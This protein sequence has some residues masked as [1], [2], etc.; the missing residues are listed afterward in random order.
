M[1]GDDLESQL[2]SQLTELRTQLAEVGA[3]HAADPSCDELREQ[4]LAA[5]Q[6]AIADLEPALLEVA[7]DRLL[8]SCDSASLQGAGCQASGIEEAAPG[9][10]ERAAAHLL[11]SAQ[12]WGQAGGGARLQASPREQEDERNA[13]GDDREEEEAEEEE[14]EEE[15]VNGS[16]E[17]VSAEGEEEGEEEEA[18]LQHSGLGAPLDV[19]AHARLAVEAGVHQGTLHYAAWE[20]HSRGIASKLLA[21]M[22][23]VKG[24]GLGSRGTGRVEPLQVLL[25]A[26][27]QGLGRGLQGQQGQ[28]EAAG[29]KAAASS[30]APA[31]AARP[32][33][34][35]RLMDQHGRVDKCQQAVAHF[36]A[37]LQ[38]N[39]DNPS[40]AAQVSKRLREAQ[41]SLAGAEAEAS[42]MSRALRDAGSGS[43]MKRAD[44][45]QRRVPV[46][47]APAEARLDAAGKPLISPGGRVEPAAGSNLLQAARTTFGDVFTLNLVGQRM[48][49]WFDPALIHTFFSAPDCLITFRP[50]VEQ[51]TQRVFGLPSKE[52]FPRHSQLLTDLRE[53]LPQTA[54]TG[55]L[56]VELYGAVRRLVF[57]ASVEVLF[58]APFMD[59]LWGRGPGRG[60]A[61]TPRPSGSAGGGG[62]GSSSRGEGGGRRV[63]PLPLEKARA[64][65][66]SGGAG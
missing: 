31:A 42:R 8:R 51:F 16:G 64:W 2:E 33:T 23:Y 56:Q 37:M 61:A 62:S 18:A 21:A 4:M 1:D 44:V 17:E 65:D 43:K 24:S 41:A 63:R 38:R 15:W 19:F 49:F 52:F 53:Q 39:R 48:Q 29:D 26:G 46:Q 22:G 13:L 35:Q 34:R 66:S 7:R 30:E 45:A 40:L 36:T 12:P 59:S 27:K 14:E 3:A 25:Q 6:E 60:A 5:L 50:A 57:L 9:A 54:L 28:G 10:A 11:A 58:G 55:P 47:P 32:D 20:Q